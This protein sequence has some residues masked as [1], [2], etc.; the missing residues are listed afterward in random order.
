M[1]GMLCKTTE[2]HSRASTWAIEEVWRRL[3]GH[4]WRD[5]GLE[6]NWALVSCLNETYLLNERVASVRGFDLN[7][8]FVYWWRRNCRKLRSQAKCIV[9]FA[10][11]SDYPEWNADSYA[12]SNQN[13]VIEERR[14]LRQPYLSSL[15]PPPM[16]YWSQSYQ[17]PNKKTESILLPWID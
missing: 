11:R 7:A 2:W 17:K 13:D 4:E 15:T 3:T 16:Q 1:R 14:T 6:G 8:V 12:T 9:L 5:W 10:P